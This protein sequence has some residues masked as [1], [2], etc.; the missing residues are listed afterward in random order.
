[1]ITLLVA[2]LAV[3]LASIFLLVWLIARGRRRENSLRHLLDL[4]DRMQSLLDRSQERMLAMQSVVGR[5][6]ADITAVAL[7]SLD[8][9]LP[10]REA[11]RDVLQHRL[12]IQQ[13][14][15]SASQRE[16]DEACGALE[17]AHALLAARLDEL[18]RTGAELAEATAA[19]V[20]A[21]RR[22]PPTLRRDPDQA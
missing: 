18:E 21:A 19:S 3:V 7:A 8:G 1:M 17:R 10:I 14:G 5:M 16:L 22:E 15:A 20:E 12:W 9:P 6:P 11:K 4:A 2:A 13:H